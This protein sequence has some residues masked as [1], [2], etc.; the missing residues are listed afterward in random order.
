MSAKSDANTT[1]THVVVVVERPLH[2]DVGCGE[3]GPHHD[4]E[5]HDG[6]HVSSDSEED[7][8][9][10]QSPAVEYHDI[11]NGAATDMPSWI[12]ETLNAAKRDTRRQPWRATFGE[13]VDC[14]FD[15]GEDLVRIEKS[16]GGRFDPDCPFKTQGS[17]LAA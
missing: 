6:K 10:P 11:D 13:S 14:R 16:V 2:R 15:D 4:R 5:G 1:H 12:E 7:D 9:R 17:S 8:S 3:V